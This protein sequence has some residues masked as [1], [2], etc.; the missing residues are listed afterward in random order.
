LED[1][2]Y[3]NAYQA[4]YLPT[5][6][7]DEA[8]P[9]FGIPNNA[10]GWKDSVVQARFTFYADTSALD[11]N[12][13][14]S[15]S[16]STWSTLLENVSNIEPWWRAATAKLRD[17]DSTSTFFREF[18]QHQK[19]YVTS[20]DLVDSLNYN[21]VTLGTDINQ[22]INFNL[23]APCQ[24]PDNDNRV[25][26]DPD[27]YLIRNARGQF[28]HVPLYSVHDSAEWR[29]LEKDEHPEL[30]PSFQWV[31]VKRYYYGTGS[32]DVT[33]TSQVT[34]TNREFPWLKFE[35][36]QLTK[37]QTKL[38]LYPKDYDWN[39]LEK[40]NSVSVSW[41]EYIAGGA[42]AD[43]ASFIKVPEPSKTNPYLG[44]TYIKPEVTDTALYAFN[45]M[46]FIDSNRYLGWNNDNDGGDSVVYANYDS[47]Y[48]RLYF[49]LDTIA[50]AYGQMAPYGYTV[51]GSRAEAQLGVG[52][53]AQ[54]VRQ[55]Y[56]LLY[57]DPYKFI[58][59][60]DMY[61][62]NG[63]ENNYQL[64]SKGDYKDILGRPA[65]YLRNVYNN[66]EKGEDYFAL[67]QI[68]DWT[69]ST[70]YPLDENQRLEALRA[71]VLRMFGEYYASALIDNLELHKDVGFINPG[72]FVAAV[73]FDGSTKLKVQVRADNESRVSTFRLE[74]VIDPI[75]RRFNTTKEGYVADDTPDT[76]RF[77]TINDRNYFLFENQGSLADQRRYWT[78]PSGSLSQAFDGGKNYLGLV[79]EYANREEMAKR[80]IHTA[81]FV[82]TAF[83]NRGTG[84]IKPQYMLAVRPDIYTGGLGCDDKNVENIPLLPY[85]IADY[86]INANDSAHLINGRDDDDY[87]WDGRWERMVFTRAI[88]ANDSLYILNDVDI[89]DKEKYRRV[90]T[91]IKGNDFELNVSLLHQLVKE[92]LVTAVDLANNRHK[93]CVFSFRL[94]ERHNPNDFLIESETTNRDTVGGPMLRPCN[95]GWLKIQNGVPVISRGL[96]NVDLIGEGDI[97]DVEKA[98]DEAPV[99]NEPIAAAEAVKIVGGNASVSILNAAG[100]AISITNTL[101]QILA[102]TVL[103]S[104]NATVPVAASGIVIVTI[105]GVSVGKTLVK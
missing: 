80:D 26:L 72:I 90:Y 54:L 102:R 87:M 104:D 76:V 65:F 77:F 46:N 105:E 43:T 2:I 67:V 6:Y 98:N 38:D 83:V 4:T 45:Y 20:Q 29:E 34:I 56:R 1:N 12:V 92:G 51:K 78:N 36:V 48:D 74:E 84:H 68:F 99:S 8:M 71:Y 7:P 55:P 17:D 53:L 100:K 16:D 39:G 94:A 60:N 31:I 73:D 50:E 86:L 27:V 79:N 88:H 69:T 9:Y 70:I 85:V 18:S 95:G 52:K 59:Y 33:G 19:L 75:Y 14:N 97:F 24:V 37:Y 13:K 64:G 35:N 3:I 61:L 15:A 25:S 49:R 32:E 30:L 42:N 93:D 101:G 66:T 81:I 5:N 89:K 58:C 96:T 63:V 44:Y 47:Y 40:T 22:Q 10:D 11:P 28:L 91:P 21:V 23:Y 103:T 82:D 57:E 41:A 62:T